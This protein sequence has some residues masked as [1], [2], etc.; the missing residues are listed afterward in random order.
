VA[1][2]APA[3]AEAARLERRRIM[4][5]SVIVDAIFPRHDIVLMEVGQPSKEI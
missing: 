2:G 1:W 3:R 4:R 5:A